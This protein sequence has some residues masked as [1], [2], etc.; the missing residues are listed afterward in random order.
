M[1]FAQHLK[2]DT[3][4]YKINSLPY[5]K[6]FAVSTK[7]ILEKFRQNWITEWNLKEIIDQMN[8]HWQCLARTCMSNYNKHHD[9]EKC[10]QIQTTNIERSH[11]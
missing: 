8:N 5:H 6:R 10:S 9:V 3:R 1:Q 11:L 2:D 4:D 7:S